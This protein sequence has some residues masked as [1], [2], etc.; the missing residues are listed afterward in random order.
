MESFGSMCVVELRELL[1]RVAVRLSKSAITGRSTCNC[2]WRARVM[3]GKS[4]GTPS[5][6]LWR[7]Y[8]NPGACTGAPA[9]AHGVIVP[10][11]AQ[12]CFQ[13]LFLGL[14]QI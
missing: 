2:Q 14:D 4:S 13:E 6:S 5:A 3:P 12:V 11:P 10:S 8:A 7:G 9:L 1:G